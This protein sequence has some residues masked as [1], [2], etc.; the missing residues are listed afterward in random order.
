M[1][2]SLK[3][4]S[5]MFMAILILFASDRAYAQNS[6]T[7]NKNNTASEVKKDDKTAGTGTEGVKP[8]DKKKAAKDSKK[9]DETKKA[10]NIERT[11][12]FGI[13]K[14]RKTAINQIRN[15]QDKDIQKKLAALLIDIIANDSDMEIRKTAITVIGD[16]KAE[17]ASGAL[18]KALN[19]ESEDVRI[20][21]CFATGRLKTAE[22]KPALIELIKKQDLTKDSNLTDA[23]ITALSDLGAPEIVPFAVEAVK[24]SKNSKM[25]REKLLLFIGNNGSAEQK[26]FLLEIYKDEDQEILMRSYAVKSIAKLKITAAAPDIKTVISEINSYQFARRKKYYDLYIHSVAALAEMGDEDAIPLLMDSLRSDNANVRLKALRLL[27]DFD[28]ERTIDIIKYKMDHDPSNS[29]RKTARKILED[30]GII[31]KSKEED[32]RGI[33]EPAEDN[34]DQREQ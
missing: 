23:A 27:K 12:K 18:I 2:Q 20:A 19:D 10:K 17:G 25:A 16:L 22:A 26:D 6:T 15:I 28:D 33:E 5:A 13:Q 3:N 30:R 8:E 24:D 4:L 21:A 32:Y 31:E 9:L 14:D 7:D 1:I 34:E 29:V 11:L